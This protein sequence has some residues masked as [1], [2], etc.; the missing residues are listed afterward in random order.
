MKFF[1]SNA[2]LD[3]PV[4]TLLLVAFSRWRSA[5]LFEDSK[6]E[7]GLDHFEVRQYPAITRHRLLTCVSYLFRA[8]FVPQSKKRPGADGV[9]G[10]DRH[11]SAGPAL[12]TRRTLLPADGQ[13]PRGAIGVNAATQRR[14]GPQPA[15]ANAAATVGDRNTP[16]RHTHLSVAEKV[17]L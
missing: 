8:E 14:G 17:A 13:K 12:A 4:E 6:T 16:T 10:A 11:A 1:L 2:P 7:L 3:T 9:P 15:Q 5:R